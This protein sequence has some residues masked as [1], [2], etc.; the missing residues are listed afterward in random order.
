MVIEQACGHKWKG[1][2]DHYSCKSHCAYLGRVVK[3]IGAEGV[4]LNE[5]LHSIRVVDSEC[6]R[7]S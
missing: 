2:I 3:I 5:D 1:M 4:G 7:A 6:C